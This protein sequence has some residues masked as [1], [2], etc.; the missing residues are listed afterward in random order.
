MK[1]RSPM[2]HQCAALSYAN[3]RDQVALFME[4]RLGKSLVGLRWIEPTDATRVLIVCPLSVIE[5]WENELRLEGHEGVALVGTAKQKTRTLEDNRGARFFL[6]NYEALTI[7]R[8]PGETRRRAIP[9][10]LAKLPWDA[11]VLDESP[12]IKNPQANVTKVAQAVLARTRYKALLTGL[13]HPEGPFDYFE[14][15]R[16]LFGSFMG[17]R[18]FWTWREKYFRLIDGTHEWYP[19][20]GTLGAIKREVH[21]L[22]F[23]C[24]RKQAKVGARKFHEV[25]RVTLP[26]KLRKVYD[27][28]ETDFVL[29]DAET[30]YSPV[31]RTWC[32]RVSGGRPEDTAH[33]GDHKLSELVR[34]VTGELADERV[35]VFF[36]FNRELHAA[37]RAL[38]KANVSATTIHGGVGRELR[39]RR[40]AMCEAGTVRVVLCQIKC[41]NMGLD[42]SFCPTAVYFS[43]SDRYEERAQSEDRI[44]SPVK[45][46]PRLIVDLVTRDTVDEDILDALRDKAC[47]AKYF[48]SR[49]VE[50]VKARR[51]RNGKS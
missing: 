23:V 35:I 7:R 46:E 3:D 41:V 49:I 14:Q 38:H 20:R 29:G 4:M 30:K 48:N 43:N 22:A 47:T 10:P 28:I 2:A 21:R 15:F 33:H 31:V 44:I 6:T 19:R 42:F 18:N 36:R 24:T 9:S 25:R 27:K 40:R 50:N 37:R 12:R 34:L 1:A 26:A 45:D 8:R 11:V 51:A 13:P 5:S 16:F 32:Q 39:A 17:C